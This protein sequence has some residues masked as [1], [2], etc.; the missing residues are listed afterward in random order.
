MFRKTTKAETNKQQAE[1][2]THSVLNDDALEKV[3]GGTTRRAADLA[4]WQANFGT[5]SR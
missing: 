5:G 3:R 1:T 4:D 2:N